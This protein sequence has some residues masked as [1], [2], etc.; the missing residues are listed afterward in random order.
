MAAWLSGITLWHVVRLVIFLARPSSTNNKS[1]SRFW[2]RLVS[3]VV[4]GHR[5]PATLA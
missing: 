5:L 3:C 1:R 2:V 4:E